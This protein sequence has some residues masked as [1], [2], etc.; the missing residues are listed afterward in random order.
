MI[1]NLSLVMVTGAILIAHLILEFAVPLLLKNGQTLGKKIFGIAVMRN[2]L[3]KITPVALF[4]RTFLGKF[5]I[6]T[7]IPA[8]MILM[9]FWGGVGLICPA[10]V[11]TILIVQ[12]FMLIF[13]RNRC[14]IHDYL[15]LCVV[16]DY[17]SQMI[18]T[19]TEDLIAY[20]QRIAAE[21]AKEQPY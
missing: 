15:S 4:I 7:M 18:F 8:I 16:V 19:S 6:E 10:T 14:V 3:T 1:V 20:Q 13:S 17:A 2:D 5:T 21:K 9:M 11:L 12:I